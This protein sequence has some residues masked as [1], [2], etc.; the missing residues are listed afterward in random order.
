MTLREWMSETKT[1]PAA[2]AALL[3]CHWVTVYKWANGSAR[4]SFEKLRRIEQ[5]TGGKVTARTLA[6]EASEPRVTD[7]PPPAPSSQPEA[8]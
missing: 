7:P 3:G 8:A 2:L 1:T 6:H 4:P 5:V